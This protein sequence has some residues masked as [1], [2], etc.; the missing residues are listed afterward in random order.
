DFAAA[1]RLCLPDRSATGDRELPPRGI[2]PA[3]ACPARHRE[4]GRSD[5][6]APA[7]AADVEGMG[8][9]RLYLHV[10]RRIRGALPRERRRLVLA[11]YR[12]DRVAG[13]FVRHASGGSSRYGAGDAAGQGR[14][15]P[16]ARFRNTL[17][18]RERRGIPMA[19]EA[20]GYRRR[21]RRSCSLS[22]GYP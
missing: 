3:V 1:R 22:S 12:L 17:S 19:V 9:R 11:A 4:A 2:S 21:R 13:G 6:A 5:R 18:I 15:T 7:T 14:A 20:P 10:D 16:T 8:L